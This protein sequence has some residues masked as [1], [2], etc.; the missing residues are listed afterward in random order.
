MLIGSYSLSRWSLTCAYKATSF[1][2]D[3][4]RVV[5]CWVTG[6]S[7]SHTSTANLWPSQLAGAA[8]RAHRAASDACVWWK[9][10]VERETIWHAGGSTTSHWPSH[11]SPLLVQFLMSCCCV[12]VLQTTTLKNES[13]FQFHPLYELRVWDFILCIHFLAIH[14]QFNNFSKC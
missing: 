14:V 1:C 7:Q 2:A 11:R 8:P 13:T 4:Y 9:N 12:S 3:N 6:A 5:C 10:R